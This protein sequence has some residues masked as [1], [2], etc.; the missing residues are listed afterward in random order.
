MSREYTI[1]MRQRELQLNDS[2]RYNGAHIDADMVWSEW[3]PLDYAET[4]EQAEARVNFW[5]ELNDY[6]V[7]QRGA[8][9]T[10]QFDIE[11]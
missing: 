7:S 2:R 1:M 8:S 4:F 10:R 11:Y 5:K 6:A 9:A 3:E